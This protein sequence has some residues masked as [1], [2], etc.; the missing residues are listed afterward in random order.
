M[1]LPLDK[2]PLILIKEHLAAMMGLTWP[3]PGSDIANRLECGV[4]IKL[5]ALVILS[6]LKITMMLIDATFPPLV[7]LLS[8]KFSL[9]WVRK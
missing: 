1:A 4:E 9:L 2:R 7:C 8:S 5:F 6:S 3:A